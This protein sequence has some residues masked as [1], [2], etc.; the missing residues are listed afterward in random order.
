MGQ[1]ITKLRMKE[2]FTSNKYQESNFLFLIEFHQNAFL[3]FKHNGLCHHTKQDATKKCKTFVQ[4]KSFCL[5]ALFCS[6]LSY[7]ACKIC[8]CLSEYFTNPIKIL[9]AKD[10]ILDLLKRLQFIYFL[11]LLLNDIIIGKDSIH[12]LKYVCFIDGILCT[13]KN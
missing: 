1:K 8:D 3:Y 12:N 5:R 7:K 10:C 2:V 13:A 6:R 11:Y 4:R 9:Y